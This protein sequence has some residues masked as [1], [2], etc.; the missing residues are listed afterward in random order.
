M[1][2][3]KKQKTKQKTNNKTKT[4]DPCHSVASFLNLEVFH[5]TCVNS[6]FHVQLHE[7]PKSLPT[8]G[9]LCD[10]PNGLQDTPFTPEPHARKQTDGK[11]GRMTLGILIRAVGEI[12]MGPRLPHAVS[13]TL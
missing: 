7:Q 6:G 5:C 1:P 13:N 10:T 8:P 11:A 12:L 2:A 9:L 4:H 3:S